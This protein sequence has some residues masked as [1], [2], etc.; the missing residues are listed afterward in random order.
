MDSFSADGN[1]AC[2]P[3]GSA[4]MEEKQKAVLNELGITRDI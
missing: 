3:A 1:F 2:M 4:V